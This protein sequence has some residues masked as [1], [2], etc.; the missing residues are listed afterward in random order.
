MHQTASC[1][2]AAPCRAGWRLQQPLGGCCCWTPGQS[3]GGCLRTCMLLCGWTQSNEPHWCGMVCACVQ[4]I[5]AAMEHTCAASAACQLTYHPC[6]YWRMLAQMSPNHPGGWS[7]V[8]VQVQVAN[9][10]KHLCCVLLPACLPACVLLGSCLLAV[11][12]T[13]STLA[14]IGGLSCMEVSSGDLVATAG[15]SKGKRQLIP[16][17]LVKVRW[18]AWQKI[19]KLPGSSQEGSFRCLAF[20]CRSY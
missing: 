4:H 20:Q 17:N 11:Q 14:H 5:A 10:L 7:C 12:A 13:A 8:D 1:C 6:S 2:C 18:L 16:D 9:H 3:A 15:Y 19:L